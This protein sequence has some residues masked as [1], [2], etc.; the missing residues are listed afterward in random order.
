M[1]RHRNQI[2]PDALKVTN[3]PKCESQADARE[4]PGGSLISGAFKENVTLSSL[5][6]ITDVDTLHPNSG[7]WRDAMNW[8]LPEKNTIFIN[9]YI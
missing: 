2:N 7:Q 9:I 1:P 8:K 5:W 4:R 6:N 3:A